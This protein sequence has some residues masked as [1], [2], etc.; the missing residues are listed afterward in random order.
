MIE[1]YI[2]ALNKR[3]QAILDISKNKSNVEI[4]QCVDC[5]HRSYN[6]FP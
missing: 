1:P 6:S 4:N 5:F 3:C 2:I